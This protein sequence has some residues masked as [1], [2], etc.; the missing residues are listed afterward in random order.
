MTDNFAVT[1]WADRGQDTQRF[2]TP[3]FAVLCQRCHPLRAIETRDT[4]TSRSDTSSQKRRRIDILRVTDMEKE[5][6]RALFW[7]YM[8]LLIEYKLKAALKTLAQT[9]AYLLI[10]HQMCGTRFAI[11]WVGH[12]FSR[13][14]VAADNSIEVETNDSSRWN[15]TTGFT[16]LRGLRTS[17]L[18]W[19]LVR[20]AVTDEGRH[21][22]DLLLNDTAL[23]CLISTVTDAANLAL[24]MPVDKPSGGRLEAHDRWSSP[25]AG[26]RPIGISAFSGLVD[27][28]AI[29]DSSDAC[30]HAHM[31]LRAICA[32]ARP[33]KKGVGHVFERMYNFDLR[34]AEEGTEITTSTRDDHAGQST[35]D[36]DTDVGGDDV[37]GGNPDRSGR[38]EAGDGDEGRA[39]D[40]S[41]GK[42]PARGLGSGSG[43]DRKGQRQQTSAGVSGIGESRELSSHRVFT[44]CDEKSRSKKGTTYRRFSLNICQETP[45]CTAICA[46]SATTSP[47]PLQRSE[48]GLGLFCL[49]CLRTSTRMTRTGLQ[50]GPMIP[51]TDASTQVSPN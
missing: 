15:I 39:P 7:G 24:A 3:D 35:T 14:F 20:D 4:T 25:L 48:A 31:Q 11:C 6:Q 50:L 16:D 27:A 19:N 18:A 43:G 1:H 30:S 41:G 9:I 46:N 5:Q 28:D 13:V 45:L 37:N 23:N 44:E 33:G 2:D 32:A 36:T 42:S 12:Y 49:A 22:S 40:E 51:T 10:A 17:S 21:V 26:A 47:R 29:R 38:D 34:D 8:S